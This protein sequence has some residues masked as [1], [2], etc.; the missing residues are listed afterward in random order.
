MQIELVLNLFYVRQ[1]RHTKQREI[2]QNIIKILNN[3]CDCEEYELRTPMMDIE[4]W[5]F[6]DIFE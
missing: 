6:Q 5:Q 1:I 3:D 4:G 2:T